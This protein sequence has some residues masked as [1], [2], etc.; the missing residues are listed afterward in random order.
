M[1][2]GKDSQALAG[3]CQTTGT[4]ADFAALKERQLVFLLVR[5]LAE[6]QF[7]RADRQRSQQLWREVAALELDPERITTLLYSGVD[8]DD[9]QA[10]E[11]LEAAWSQ[12]LR[13]K[14]WLRGLSRRFN[15][16]GSGAWPRNAP[17]AAAPAHH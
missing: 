13:V 3:A 10:L 2:T 6:A 15:R 1:T 9:R 16:R 14:G 8:L 12:P 4:S 11:E 17:P 7:K 5:Q